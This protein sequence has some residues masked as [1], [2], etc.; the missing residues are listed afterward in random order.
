MNYSPGKRL[1]LIVV[2]LFLGGCATTTGAGLSTSESATDAGTPNI[3]PFERVNRQVYAF[4][5]DFDNKILIPI[6]KNYREHVPNPVRTAIYN[7]FN[8]VTEPRNFINSLLQGKLHNA[9]DSLSRL[10]VN[11]TVGLGGF[12][13]IAT[14]SGLE[15][16]IE[17][18]GQTLAVWGFGPGP[19]IVL[20]I[21]GPSSGRDVFGVYTYFNYTDPRGYIS[22]RAARFSMFAVDLV[23]TRSRFLRA[24][25]VFGFASLDPYLFERE[26]YFQTRND[27]IY[28]GRPPI[29]E[30]GQ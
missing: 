21:L 17:D 18:I 16:R 20:P 23:D 8:N 4:N 12:I 9:A 1:L 10:L 25:S 30:Y 6:A 29:D 26:S 22:D 7:F 2:I 19:Y 15:R 3:D 11:T 27:L 5:Q 24:T 28:D 13:D 14:M